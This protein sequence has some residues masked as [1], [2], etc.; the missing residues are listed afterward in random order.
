MEKKEAEVEQ[1]KGGN[2]RS[3]TKSQRGRAVSPFHI[4]RYGMSTSIKPET[5]QRPGDDN[6]ISEVTENMMDIRS[7]FS[8][9]N[10]RILLNNEFFTSILWL[11]GIQARSSSSSKQRRS[12]FPS[13][14]TNKEILLKMPIL[15]EER[16]ASAVKA[17]S[18]SLPW[19]EIL[20][21][22]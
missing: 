11:C 20:I 14:L 6:R 12:R 3:M 7:S 4:P 21:H 18:P 10:F 5:S 8:G 22:R 19:E 16:L 17:R 1:L 15:A 2:V 13:A 9:L